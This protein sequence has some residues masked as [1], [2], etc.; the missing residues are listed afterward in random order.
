MGG[1]Y[2]VQVHAIENYQLDDFAIKYLKLHL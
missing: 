1:F 2:M